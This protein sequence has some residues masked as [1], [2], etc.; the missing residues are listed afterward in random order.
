LSDIDA[1]NHKY[2]IIR[3]KNGTPGIQGR[4]FIK[5][6]SIAN[7][8]SANMAKFQTVANDGGFT[9]YTIDLSTIAGWDGTLKGLRIDPALE[10]GIVEIDYVKLSDKEAS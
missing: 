6:N 9:T 8:G 4:V 10:H 5:N 2:L 1:S 7:Y 3:M